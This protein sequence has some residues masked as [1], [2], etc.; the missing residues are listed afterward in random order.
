[1]QKSN[2]QDVAPDS[3][4]TGIYITSIH[5]I[6]FRQKEYAINFWVWFNY[7][8]RSLDFSKYLE[9][10]QAKTMSILYSMTDT[11]D[12]DRTYVL[13]KL[14]CTMKDNWKINNFPFN[15][16]NLRFSIENSQYDNSSLVFVKDSVGESYDKHA[17]NGYGKDSLNGWNIDPDSFKIS[18]T[19]R[20]YESAFGDPSIQPHMEYS[21]YKVKIGITRSAWGMFFKIFLGMYVA[22]L[23]AYVCFYIHSDG[24][25]ARFGL[26]VGA[27]F[28]VVGN[29]YVIESSLPESS[30]FTLVDQLHGLTLLVIFIVIAA[31]TRC[32]KLIKE[33]KK[34]KALQFDIIVRRIVLIAYLALNG[35]LIFSSLP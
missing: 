5:D 27:L 9:I 31:T 29:K 2:A 7:K 32:L 20:A 19:N 34:E 28:A 23:I 18:I 16:Q 3:V 30:T 25:D 8:N 15:R 17:L 14:Q 1:M 10:P 35:W 21:A 6:D 33:N 11:S 12:V 4:R 26:S 13:L 24:I 22:F